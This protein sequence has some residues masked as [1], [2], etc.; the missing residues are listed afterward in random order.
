[1]PPL[2]ERAA[3]ERVRDY[4]ERALRE[5]RLH[6]HP[7]PLPSRGWFVPPALATDLPAG[8]SVLGD[9]IFG[10]QGLHRDFVEPAREIGDE[11]ASD[12]NAGRRT[13]PTE[14]EQ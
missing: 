9:E 6:A 5:G 1:M 10:R 11:M 3:Q 7:G 2:I 14:A 8:S 4:Q 12:G 13:V